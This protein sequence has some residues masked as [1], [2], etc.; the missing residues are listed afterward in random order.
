VVITASV[1]HS[2]SI[3][4]TVPCG[5]LGNPDMRTPIAHALAWPERIDSGVA[6]L[7]LFSVAQLTSSGRIWC[8]SPCLDLGSRLACGGNAAAVSRKRDGQWRHSRP[9]GLPFLACRSHCGNAGRRAQAAPDPTCL[10]SWRP[11]VRRR[12]RR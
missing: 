12:R 11:T 5:P 2:W 3:T 1:I 10:R 9:S 7:D 6:P 4:R 8:A